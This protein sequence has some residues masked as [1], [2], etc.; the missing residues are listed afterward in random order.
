[1]LCTEVL[2]NIN[3][4]SSVI[5]LQRRLGAPFEVDYVDLEWDQVHARRL[6]V[7]S[8][9]GRVVEIRLGERVEEIGL[10][11]GDVLGCDV[12]P[13]TLAAPASS[14]EPCAAAAPAPASG[15]KP[16]VVA[17]QLRSARM[18][19]IR[20]TSSE[21]VD[22]ALVARVGWEV[23]NMH[24]PLFRGEAGEL[25]APHSDALQ[26]L[27]A[28]IPGIQTTVEQV[29]LDPAER[30]SGT[31]ISTVVRLSPALKVV[32]RKKTSSN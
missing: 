31:G 26:R 32:V 18:V 21:P 20:F 23:G 25:M 11:D 10:K 8:G 1:M 27:L 9:A 7:K 5:A 13:D 19:R 30:L 16:V 14:V 17:V 2:G 3:D 28:S 24:V 6:V 12:A 4:P 15:A 29:S 22:S